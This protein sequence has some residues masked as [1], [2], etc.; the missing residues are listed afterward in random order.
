MVLIEKEWISFG[1]QFAFRSGHCI[2]YKFLKNF[3]QEIVNGF[4]IFSS[5]EKEIDKKYLFKEYILVISDLIRRLNILMISRSTSTIIQ[6]CLN[7]IAEGLEL[8]FQT[9]T[10]VKFQPFFC[11]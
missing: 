11:H 8:I 4:K 3:Y 2:F 1:H 9:K 5:W 6:S 7:V 10:Q